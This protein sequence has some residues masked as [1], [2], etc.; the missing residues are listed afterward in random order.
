[1]RSDSNPDQASGF[2]QETVTAKSIQADTNDEILVTVKDENSINENVIE[3]VSNETDE[4]TSINGA[5]EIK[6]SRDRISVK[7]DGILGL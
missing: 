5:A 3:D 6:S 1:M 7:A 4:T 2:R